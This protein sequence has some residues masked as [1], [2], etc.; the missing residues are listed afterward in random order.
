MKKIIFLFL[1]ICNVIN[2]QENVEVS[3]VGEAVEQVEKKQ[4]FIEVSTVPQDAAVTL[5]EL[6]SIEKLVFSDDLDE[7]KKELKEIKPYCDAIGMFLKTPEYTSISEHNVRSLQKMQSELSIYTKQ[8]EKWEIELQK[9]I[10]LYDTNRKLLTEYSQTWN[11]TH[12]NAIKEDAPE[13][14]KKHISSVSLKISDLAEKIKTEYDEVLTLSQVVISNVLE[15]KNQTLLLKNRELLV[16]QNIFFKSEKPFFIALQEDKFSVSLYK[17][18]VSTSFIEKYNETLNYFDTHN[19]LFVSFFIWYIA[20][21]IFILYLYYL[22]RRKQLFINAESYLK[23]EFF[24]IRKFFSVLIIYFMLLLVAIFPNRPESLV[25]TQL[26]LLLIPIGS[27]FTTLIEKKH[28]K[29]IYIFSGILFVFIFN[30]NAFGSELESR[31]FMLTLNIGLFVYLLD[32]IRKKILHKLDSNLL[33]KIVHYSVLI[34]TF[35]LPIAIVTNLYGAVLLSNRI[36]ELVLFVFYTTAIFYIL[37]TILVGY[38]I[39]VLRRR[40]STAS[41]MLEKYSQTIENT[42]KVLVDIW[43]YLWWALVIVKLLGTYPYLIS[44]IE[45]ILAF[46]WSI[47]ETKISIQSIVDFT[48]IVVATWVIAKLMKVL[49]EV[50]LFSRFKF[51]RGA[52]TAILTVLNYIIVISGTIISFS[53]LGVS[54]QQFAI[55]FGALGVG[56]GFGLRNIIANFVSGIIMVFERPVQIGDVIE[57]DKTMGSV[58]SIGARAS[59]LQ[60]FDGSEVIIPNADFIGKE[61]VNWTLSDERRRKTVEF[62]VDLDNDIDLILKIMKDIVVSHPDVLKDPEP[63][64]AFKGFGEYTLEFKIYF[65][66]S[67]NLIVAQ[68]D[69]AIGIYKA[70]QKEG[71]K[72]PVPKTH[73]KRDVIN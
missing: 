57:I 13:A 61:I 64:A 23:K 47:A 72:M 39:I 26:L 28:Y 14:I 58:Q 70:L 19:E 11:E 37:R 9:K 33:R 55:I 25:E 66:L 20:G 8:L 73:L 31:I 34:S 41:Y 65:W 49:L 12:T 35:F 50:E 56:I 17:L 52:P 48:I 4:D 40:I 59:T 42:T 27:I 71:V 45:T 60:T 16:G 10:Q 38:V 69:I 51:P 22:Y 3:S 6:K 68:S 32:V 21:A 46:S 1:L 43:M 36:V 54:S 62:K 7:H 5:M 24:Y 30:K 53:S 18:H 63:L 29:Y 67:D 15:L 2:A 44:F